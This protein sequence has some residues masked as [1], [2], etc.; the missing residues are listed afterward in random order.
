MRRFALVAMAALWVASSAAGS[1]G[2]EQRKLVVAVIDQISWHDLLDRETKIPTLRRLME[3]GAVGMMCARTA[4]SREGA[5]LTMGCGARAFARDFGEPPGPEAFAFDVGERVDGASAAE[6]YRA[7]MGIRPEGVAIV[8]LGIG[9]LARQNEAATYSVHLGLLG[10]ELTRAGLSVACVGNADTDAAPHREIAA[11][12]MDERGMVARGDVGAALAR[13]S[14]LSPGGA[15]TDEQRFLSDFAEAAKSAD[16]VFAELGDTARVGERAKYLA[17]EAA[18]AARREALEHSDRLLAKALALMPE[19][20]WAVMVL[21]PEVRPPDPGERLAALAPVILGGPAARSG[22]LTS[23]STRRAGLVV[24]TDVAAT[25]LDFF[26]LPTP[27]D[28]IGRPMA[29]TPMEGDA[30]QWLSAQVAREDVV[31]PA[32]KLLLRWLPIAGAAT[33]W[34]AALLLLLGDRAPN[35]T[36]MLVRAALA[37]ILSVPFTALLAGVYPFSFP[38]V[39]A[40]VA[41]GAVALALASGWVTMWRAA[42]LGAAALLVLGLGYGLLHGRSLLHWSPFSYSPVIGARFYGIGNEFGGALLGAMLV[43]VGGVLVSRSAGLGKRAS[44]ALALAVVVVLVGD[45]RLGANV[46][47]ALA[48]AVGFGV[49]MLYLWRDEPGWREVLAVGTLL[50][51]LV[52]VAVLAE[53]LFKRGETSHVGLLVAAVKARGWM[54]VWETISRKVAMNMLLVQHSIWADTAAAA[55]AVLLVTTATRSAQAV[56]AMREHEWLGPVLT[57]GLFGAAA[58]FLLNDSGVVAAGAA[59]L[60]VVGWFSYAALGAVAN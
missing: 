4:R 55:L 53:V 27:P 10:G 35:W 7:Y 23:P 16:V 11:M 30:T 15:V 54:P 33:L 22:V 41:G 12:A 25:V 29:T 49:F 60:F 2:A 38:V 58:A 47:M 8:H 24:N 48:C 31:E 46:G 3:Q 56:G 21:V 6:R 39:W 43:A 36:R 44:A 17:P 32:R 9:D 51:G 34:A 52:G 19:D 45:T 37:V 57:A 59:L 14:P 5:Y 50:A 28:T 40:V 42:P 26:G 1:V 18:A 13:R 20:G